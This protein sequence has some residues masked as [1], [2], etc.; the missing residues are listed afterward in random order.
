MK[1]RAVSMKFSTVVGHATAILAL[2]YFKLIC[3][4]KVMG[5]DNLPPE[6]YILAANHVSYLDWILLYSIF[7]FFYGKR[8]TF[9][10]KAKLFYHFPLKYLTEYGG[11][12]CLERNSNSTHSIREALS[13]LKSGGILGIFP[14]GT[15]SDTGKLQKGENGIGLIASIA[16]VPVVPV[17]LNGFHEMLP[18]GA[19]LPRIARGNIKIG[20]P[21]IFNKIR[22]ENR[23]EQIVKTI[24]T[25]IGT[26]TGQEYPYN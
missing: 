3:G 12:I 25:R 13:V 5:K 26:L 10:A 23:R 6:P 15:R 21:I 18:K 22:T 1:Q 19:V 4:G 20:K 11:A 2:T 14:E 8:I 17:G 9:V 16:G 24:M 7:R